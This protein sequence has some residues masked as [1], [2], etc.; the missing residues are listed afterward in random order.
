MELYGH[1]HPADTGVNWFL[2][3]ENGHFLL[4][5]D[6]GIRNDLAP[7]LLGKPKH[8]SW[9]KNATPFVTAQT[10]NLLTRPSGIE[11]DK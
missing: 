3:L 4:M 11:M 9:Q 8:S 1:S 6:T 10:W 7:P 5:L 2:G